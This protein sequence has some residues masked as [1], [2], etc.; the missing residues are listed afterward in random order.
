MSVV[1][2]ARRTWGGA[3]EGA[4]AGAVAGLLAVGTE[5]LVRTLSGLAS[6]IE[7]L[8]DQGTRFIPGPIFEFL[9]SIFGHTAKY[10]YLTGI[11]LAQIVGLALLTALAFAL[12]SLVLR[13]RALAA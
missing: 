13:R 8:G 10:L 5:A 7:L 6:P 11:L 2:S 1:K 9:L 12:R 4:L 3:S